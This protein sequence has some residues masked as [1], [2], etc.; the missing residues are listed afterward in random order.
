M[1]EIAI[2][3]S[4]GSIGMQT[5]DV[6]RLYPDLFHASVIAAKKNINALLRQAEE[7]HPHTI[8]VTDEKAGK[9]FKDLYQGNA[10]VLIGESALTDCVCADDV[11]LVLVSVVGIAGLLP[12]LTAIKNRKEIA[13]A[14]K[15]TLVAGGELV[16]AAAKEN[17]VLIR[18]VDSE[19]S[20]IFQSILG[21]DKKG[22]HKLIITASGGPFRGYTKEQLTSV[23]VEE[24][25]KHPT[26]QMGQK[27]TLDSATMFNKGLEVIEAHWLFDID[28][29]QIEVVVQPQSLIHSMVEY[30][31]GSIMAQLGNPDMRLPIQ[32]ALTYPERKY[33]PSHEFMDWSQISSIIIER[34]NV[35]VFRSLPLAFEAGKA[36]GDMTTVFNAANE[37]AIR[38]FISGRISFLQIY[39]VV[40]TVLTKWHRSAITSVE[41]ILQADKESR[42]LAEEIISRGCIC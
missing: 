24:A 23:T 2:L 5:M 10:T 19:H 6:L 12:T 1:K 30:K 22:I 17:A 11:D 26:W 33:S 42:L 14:N 41:D 4:T 20:A 28:Y 39:D 15:E 34:P 27:V 8:V 18:P 37:E 38:A 21:Q 40:E 13:L 29:N 35:Q 32:F 25:M 7:F 3:G 9:A 31:D 36:G 16:M